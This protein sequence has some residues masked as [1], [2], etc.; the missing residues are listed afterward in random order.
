MMVESIIIDREKNARNWASPLVQGYSR[1]FHS[2]LLT[3]DKTNWSIDTIARILKD[4]QKFLQPQKCHLKIL[5]ELLPKSSS[6][7]V[8]IALIL[9]FKS[10]SF[11]FCLTSTSGKYFKAQQ[12]SKNVCFNKNLFDICLDLKCTGQCSN[13][14][15]LSPGLSNFHFLDEF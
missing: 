15:G 14:P 13:N 10:M 3:R 8:S 6:S 11:S 5:I 9:A 2:Q 1:V 12:A 4:R 7:A